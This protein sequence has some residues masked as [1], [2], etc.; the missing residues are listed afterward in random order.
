MCTSLE[1]KVAAITMS[2]LSKSASPKAKDPAWTGDPLPRGRHKLPR[3]AVRAS[4][5]ERLLKAM[6]ELVGERGYEATTAPQVIATARVSSN[7]FYSFFSDKTDCFIALVDERSEE[8]VGLLVPDEPEP[9]NPVEALAML[10]RGIHAYLDW[11]QN[12]PAVAR[13]YF[14]ELPTA[15]ARAIEQRDRSDEKFAAVHRLIAERARKVY[16]DAT[17]VREV[18]VRASVILTTELVGRHVRSGRL[19]QVDELYSDLRYLLLRLLVGERGV[20]DAGA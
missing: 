9:A 17:P 10:D 8:L 4:Q 5:K 19:D 3:E 12:D 14:V 15:G 7:T 20:E 6:A 1:V 18:D 13:A 16:P 2:P 11:C